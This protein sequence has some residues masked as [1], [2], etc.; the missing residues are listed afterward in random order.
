MRHDACARPVRGWYQRPG[1]FR[2]V[3]FGHKFSTRSL[4]EACRRI[5]IKQLIRRE[6]DQLN[7]FEA[8]PK[9]SPLAENQS[10]HK[11]LRQGFGGFLALCDSS[12]NRSDGAMA[13][14][15]WATILEAVL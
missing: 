1:K 11:M 5:Y 12:C 7:S 15:L 2:N 9:I 10:R 6:C 8:G 4:A 14:H 13:Q 3:D